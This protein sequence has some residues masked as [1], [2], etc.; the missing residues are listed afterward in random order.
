MTS[1]WR[2]P[3]RIPNS[4]G[5]ELRRTEPTLID[6]LDVITQ[7]SNPRYES[8]RSE[9]RKVGIVLKHPRRVIGELI[10]VS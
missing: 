8:F 5:H 4:P 1:T 7:S 3:V 6:L 9:V 2:R 10:A